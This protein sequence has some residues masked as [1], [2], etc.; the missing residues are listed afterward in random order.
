MIRSGTT[1]YNDM[2]FAVGDAVETTIAIGI[3]ATHGP[4]VF[5]FPTSW[6]SG[7]EECLTKNRKFLEEHI[8]KHEL[9]R[10]AMCPHAPYTVPE[11]YI[12]E[13]KAICN[14][15]GVP[16]HIHVQETQGEMEDSMNGVKSASCHLS[17]A[18]C[19]PIEVW[20]LSSSPLEHG[21]P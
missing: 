9:V 19:T 13:A 10:Y 2:Y 17:D 18:H 21:E 7:P 20:L 1:C 5:G 12:I 16:M 14:E 11:K 15:L 4:G 3:R 6:A 8:G